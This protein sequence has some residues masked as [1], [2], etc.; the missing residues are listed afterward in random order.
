MTG[1][2]SS[3]SIMPA[4]RIMLASSMPAILDS[5]ASLLLTS[6]TTTKLLTPMASKRRPFILLASPRMKSELFI[7]MMKK[8]MAS[9]MEILSLLE[10]S[11][12]WRKS[13]ENST[14][15][16]LDPLTASPL[17][18]PPNSVPMCQVGLR[19]KSKCQFSRNSS[20]LKRVSLTHFLLSPKKC[21]SAVGK[22]SDTLNN[23]TLFL[24]E[25]LISGQSIK[26]SLTILASKMQHNY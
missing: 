9:A 8:S 16:L 15:L 20:H 21:Q 11:K 3:S 10:K 26:D 6:E 24:T 19:L 22:N 18:T 23:F 17:A 14:K 12:A 2:I 5:M 1:N 13:M 7:C 25:F 4:D